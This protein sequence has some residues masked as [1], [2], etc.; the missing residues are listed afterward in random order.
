MLEQ[1]FKNA[2]GGSSL[3][4]SEVMNTSGIDEDTG[5]IPGL[6]LSV[7]R[8]QRCCELWCRLQTWP[9]SGIALAVA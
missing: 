8:I 6:P 9:G 5:L 3:C 7:L 4:G 2:Y 1:D